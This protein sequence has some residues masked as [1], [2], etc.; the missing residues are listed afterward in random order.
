MSTWSCDFASLLKFHQRI[1]ALSTM[2]MHNNNTIIHVCTYTYTVHLSAYCVR[3][4]YMWIDRL[5]RG[6]VRHAWHSQVRCCDVTHWSPCV[7]LGQVSFR[8]WSLLAFDL[9]LP[10]QERGR[11]G[12]V[13]RPCVMAAQASL[14]TLLV[15]ALQQRMDH[16]H[17]NNNFSLIYL[18]SVR[19]THIAE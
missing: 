6:Y 14:S 11:T 15:V 17:F 3:Y 18:C 16:V 2:F 5:I 19:L 9:C 12:R 1:I 13:K 8:R 7:T 10:I 4:G